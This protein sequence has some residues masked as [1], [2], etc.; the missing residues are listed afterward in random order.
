MKPSP[1]D[2][3]AEVLSE[4]LDKINALATRGRELQEAGKSKQS[5]Q[6]YAD[7]RKLRELYGLIEGTGMR[8][9]DVD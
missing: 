4:I 9:E 7:A 2:F 5:R 1:E 8:I 3:P 6:A